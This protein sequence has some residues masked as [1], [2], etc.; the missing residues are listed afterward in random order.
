MRKEGDGEEKPV[1]DVLL[2]DLPSGQLGFNFAG[3]P[4]RNGT[5]FT[6]EL[7]L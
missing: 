7:S 2:S 4:L 5:E 6:V 1:K 3:D